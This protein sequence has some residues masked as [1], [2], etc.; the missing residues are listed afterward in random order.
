MEFKDK[1]RMRR[2]ELNLTLDD[3]AKAV[4]VSTPTVLRWESGEIKNVRRDKIEKI[5]AAL[6][7]SPSYLMGWEERP[8]IRTVARLESANFTPEEERE[9][10]A[11]MDF[12]ESKRKKETKDDTE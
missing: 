1:I 4:G 11:F 10:M 2:E 12:L 8:K 6:R 7:V 3:V 9:L 5:A